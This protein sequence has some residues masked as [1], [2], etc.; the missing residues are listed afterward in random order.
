MKKYSFTN[1]IG[2]FAPAKTPAAIVDR[3]GAEIAK[4]VKEPATR[5]KLLAAGVEPMGLAGAE[6]TAFLT[7]ERNRY[8]TIAKER[9]IK[10]EE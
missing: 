10:F 8:K 7:S 4:I 5:D 3:L 2:V 1:W 9:A 6:F